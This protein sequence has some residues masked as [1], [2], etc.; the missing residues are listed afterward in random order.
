MSA[1]SSP[2]TR[3]VRCGIGLSAAVAEGLCPACLNRAIFSEAELALPEEELHGQ[4][5]RIGDYELIECIARGDMGIVYRARQVSL[6]REVAVKILLD[7]VFA[8]PEEL[9]RFR[10][11]AAAAAALRHPNVV[12]VHEIGEADGRRF[13]SMD[14]VA[15]KDLAALTRD[16][17]LDPR[18]AAELTRKIA[19]AIA[20]THQRGILHRDLKPSNVLVD[21]AGEPHVTDFGLAKRIQPPLPEKPSPDSAKLTLSGQIVGTPGYMSPE[22]AATRKDIGPATDI[23][24]LGALFFHLLTGRAPFLG[25]TP[26]AVLRQVEELEPIAPMLLNPQVPA[27]LQTICLKCINKEPS[28][29]Y[30]SAAE[31][32]ADLGR[33]LR[34]EPIQARPTGSVERAV[35]WS[36]RHP[37]IAGMSGA[38]ALLLIVVAIGSLVYSR[39][40]EAGRRAEAALRVEAE[41]RLRQGERLINFMLGDLSDRLQPVGRLDILESALQQVDQFYAD[42][43]SDH[44]SPESQRHRA[45]TLFQAATIHAE[46]GRLAESI[47]NYHA[48]IDGY[49]RLLAAYP[50]NLQWRFELGRARNDLGI[51]FLIL[52]Q[53]T[54]ALPV[55]Q[56][57]LKERELLCAGNPTN[58]QWLGGYGS[59]AVNLGTIFR[60]LQRPSE[61]M[62]CFAKA[63]AAFR[64]WLRLD[65]TATA[66]KDRL[67]T[68]RSSQ[69]RLYIDLH[70]LDLAAAAF[71]EKIQ[72]LHDLLKK[73]AKDTRRRAELE[74]GLAYLAEFEMSRSN[75][76]AALA[77][78]DEAVPIG[79]QLSARDPSNREWQGALVSNLT[80]RGE[81]LRR[82]QRSD[83][84]FDSFRRVWE[85]S[86]PQE[87]LARPYAEWMDNW[88]QSLKSGEALEL[89]RADRAQSQGL[90]NKA[91]EFRLAAASLHGKW[92]ALARWK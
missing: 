17:P 8:S 37:G 83:E 89:Q 69:G 7:Q 92:Q 14:F 82:L 78:L 39:R 63:E 11:E 43:P 50:T 84:A 72:I 22:Q 47:T 9:A 59:T 38:I 90:T 24:S 45:N 31:L 81:V 42:I 41:E 88:R 48:A 16:G 36:R 64:E 19:E 18:Q 58:T 2:P 15:G 34:N 65:P 32:A 3:C 4:P 86:E 73:D 25:P 54:N 91:A 13:Y 62:D 60:Y 27:D 74:L 20:H 35:R 10:A 52:H 30:A 70:Q 6:N 80:D 51:A 85:M 66:P 61:A 68:L 46:Q 56:E 79:E 71:N 75:Y 40:I 28:R 26:T 49:S 67:A 53:Y 23:Y 77:P 76:L 33:F 5:Q 12:A 57:T 29:R 55:L 21:A 1:P 44:L 87:S